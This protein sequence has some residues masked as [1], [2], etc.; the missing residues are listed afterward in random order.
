MIT[1][2]SAALPF[3]VKYRDDPLSPGP[4]RFHLYLSKRL[5]CS[6]TAARRNRDNFRIR[7]R[8]TLCLAE[9]L[10]PEA[11]RLVVIAGSGE[12]DRRWQRTAR[13][14][15]E[16]HE[17]KFETTYLF[18]LPYSKLVAEL[19]KVPTD[20]IVILLTVFADGEGKTFVPAQVAG[21]SVGPFARAAL[22]TV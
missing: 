2:G 3:I 20:A 9:Q 8:K 13:E 5:C 14:L 15:L 12:A 4:D 6:A 22:R 17:R 11:R 18:E 16:N 1:F 19:S 10:Q 21:R 7:P